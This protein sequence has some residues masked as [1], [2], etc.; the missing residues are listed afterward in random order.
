MTKALL[1]RALA[2]VPTL[3]LATFVVFLLVKLVPGD[4]AVTIAGEQATAEQLAII[5]ENLGLNDPLPVQYWNWLSDALSGDLGRSVHSGEGVTDAIRRTFPPTLQIVA[6]GMIV[7]IA[8]GVPAGVASGRRA[9]SPVDGTVS[10]LST[11][12]VALPSFW[13]GLVLVS[14]FAL[15]WGW[16]PAT[17]FVS[18][19]DGLLDSWRSTVLPAV[20]IGTVGAAE[21]TRQ[22][23]SAMVEELA[24]D[25]VRTLRAKGLSERSLVWKHALRNCSVPLLTVLG[26][27]V[28]RFLGATVVIE[29]VFGISGLGTLVVGATQ[30]QDIPLV[31]GVILVMVLVVMATSFVVDVAYR[32]IDPRIS[33]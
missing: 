5:R 30:R 8:L 31:Q 22:L 27:Q 26:L 20:A 21:V 9:N 4:P 18:M 1:W 28:N 11:L 32:L 14:L 33:Q 23:R 6:G 12:G 25:H 29:A 16:F 17:G 15:R 19:S 13:L 10:T 2:A 7:A 24:S 3:L